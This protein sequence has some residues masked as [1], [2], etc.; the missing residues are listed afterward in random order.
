LCRVI[1]QLEKGDVLT[2]RRLDRLARSTRDLLS[3]LAAITGS[4]RFDKVR[5]VKVEHHAGNTW[6]WTALEAKLA[7]VWRRSMTTW[8]GGPCGR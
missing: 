6:T 4:A 8:L 7:S 1:G 5:G 3:T 2:V